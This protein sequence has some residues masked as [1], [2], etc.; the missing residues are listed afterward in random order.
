MA[1][2]IK[3]SGYAIEPVLVVTPSSLDAEKG[4]IRSLPSKPEST[5][6]DW[7]EDGLRENDILVS[8]HGALLLTSNM[9]N[10]LFSS[11]FIA[12][13]CKDHLSALWLWALLNSSVG[14]SIL[15]EVLNADSQ[16]AI[17]RNRQRRVSVLMESEVP[18][19]PIASDSR[20]LSLATIHSNLKHVLDIPKDI[21][22]GW[23]K[24]V[25]LENHD[26]WFSLTKIKEPKQWSGLVRLSDVVNDV[27]PGKFIGNKTSDFLV[28]PLP[29]IGL[30]FLRNPESTELEYLE[31][32]ET[33]R[34]GLPGDLIL[35]SLYNRF[36]IYPL[37]FRCALGLDVFAISPRSLQQ[38]Q[39]L[40]TVLR[41]QVVQDQVSYI[42]LKTVI[43]RLNRRDVEELRLPDLDNADPADSVIWESLSH[44]LDT[45]L[46]S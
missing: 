9:T 43:G 34:I 7:A 45:A 15:T 12:L 23:L 3:A 19:A 42:Q 10:I 44:R 29:V 14:R 33:L 2:N 13:R 5:F 22:T 24:T 20:M 6:Y 27:I 28:K 18:K 37:D 1:R 21:R 8:I 40:Q 32:V 35:G 46:W 39:Y 31:E 36:Y 25:M 17:E 38:R 30:K 16:V 4:A 26:D 11:R 41:S